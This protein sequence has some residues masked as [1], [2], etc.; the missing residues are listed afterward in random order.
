MAPCPNCGDAKN[1]KWEQSS[2]WC[3]SCVTSVLADERAI[4]SPRQSRQI[5]VP[6]E[7]ILER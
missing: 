3:A 6:G 7:G 2:P 5:V 4:D 1:P